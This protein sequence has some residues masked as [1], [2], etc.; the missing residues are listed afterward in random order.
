MQSAYIQLIAGPSGDGEY[1]ILPPRIAF[2]S[3]R[4]RSRERFCW[5]RRRR[6]RGRDCS[7]RQRLPWPVVCLAGCRTRWIMCNPTAAD[8]VCFQ[9][10]LLFSVMQDEVCEGLVT[11]NRTSVQQWAC[12]IITQ[13]ARRKPTERN[14]DATKVLRMETE[15][16]QHER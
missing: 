6:G 13:C 12:G 14:G 10:G 5:E 7:V 9:G 1:C 15:V 2:G 3:T 8:G 16:S 11:R 4:A